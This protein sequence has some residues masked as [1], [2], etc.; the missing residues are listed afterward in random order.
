MPS[1]PRLL[2]LPLAR[3]LLDPLDAAK[4][5][6]QVQHHGTLAMKLRMLSRCDALWTGLGWNLCEDA[7]K[8]VL[9]ASSP[10]IAGP[11]SI[12]VALPLN[13]ARYRCILERVE[14]R[15]D[16]NHDLPTPTK[17]ERQKASDDTPT[18]A[19]ALAATYAEGGVVALYTGS[20][21][22]ILGFATFRFFYLGALSFVPS[23][24]AG[25]AFGA[26]LANIV[27]Q[28][29]AIGA[30][31]PLDLCR[32]RMIHDV[33]TAGRRGK[34]PYASAL[35]CMR[36]MTQQEGGMRALYHGVGV[37]IAVGV[38]GS[39]VRQGLA[40]AVLRSSA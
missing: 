26:L 11:L 21:V 20:G 14:C 6:A 35:D 2:P 28:V 9:F 34:V 1:I 24:A 18:I 19:A 3:V 29:V 4:F 31:Y 40:I 32:A 37:A 36:T 33:V 16:R 27:P 30:S 39:L 15:L 38:A 22:A 23:A 13:F 17:G 25:S 7:L 10:G 8:L 5:L 12:L